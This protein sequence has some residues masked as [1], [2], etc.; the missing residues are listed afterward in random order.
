MKLKL[1]ATLSIFCVGIMMAQEKKWTLRDCVEYALEHN[2]SIK[3]SELDL[4]NADL[5]EADAKGNFLPTVN[6]NASH[7]W[8]IG[9]NQ[10]ITTGLFENITTQYTSAGVNVGVDIYN[11]LQNVNRLRRAN[12]SILA[13]QYRLDNMKD[14]I[15][16]AVANAYLQI[17]FILD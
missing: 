11:G 4:Q 8:N 16:L 3:Q 5:A 1:T 9:L 17:L 12:L 13:N 6:A 10:N 14:D 2:I 7:S 15:S